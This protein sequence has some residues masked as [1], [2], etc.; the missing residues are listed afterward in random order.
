MNNP[1]LAMQLGMPWKKVFQK[2]LDSP[3]I[4]VVRGWLSK[5]LEIIEIQDTSISRLKMAFCGSFLAI[6]ALWGHILQ[7]EGWDN[8]TEI[9]GNVVQE[10]PEISSRP[11]TEE[12]KLKW[13]IE[14]Y[15]EKRKKEWAG[16][17][18]YIDPV[19]E[20]I[21]KLRWEQ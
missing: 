2:E 8:P 15:I 5:S 13:T 17:P 12:E 6:I 16:E 18:G 10:N 7:R 19:E 14:Y 4:E 3:N 1:E 9:S 11:I 21:R 20:Q